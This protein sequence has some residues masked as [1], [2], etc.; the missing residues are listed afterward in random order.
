MTNCVQK[1]CLFFIG[2]VLLL[3]TL[4]TWGNVQSGS[5][6]CPLSKDDIIKLPTS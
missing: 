6:Q 2:I 3:T 5:L 4:V 1:R